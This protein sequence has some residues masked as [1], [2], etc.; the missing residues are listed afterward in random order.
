[1]PY[2]RRSPNY[3]AVVRKVAADYP[4]EWEAAR[5][6]GDKRTSDAFV[7]RLAWVLFKMDPSVGLNGKRGTDELS[8]DALAYKNPTAPGGSEVIDVIVGATHE[9][10][11]QDVTQ[12]GVLSKWIQ[13][14]DPGAPATPPPAPAPAGDLAAEVRALRAELDALKG[15]CKTVAETVHAQ[16]LAL[17]TDVIRVGSQLGLRMENGMNIGAVDGGPTTGGTTIRFVA[18]PW[19]FA[20][21]TFTVTKPGDTA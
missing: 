4:L 19:T 13:P 17:E 5:K 9:P 1:M 21:E 7:R 6:V 3:L 10:A 12:D 15:N 2:S 8:L 18:Q 11:W 16:A 14:T 20:W